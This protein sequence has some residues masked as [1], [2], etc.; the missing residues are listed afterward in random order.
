MYI[1]PCSNG[2]FTE[3]LHSPKLEVSAVSGRSGSSPPEFPDLAQK[4]I[5]REE[6]RRY[7]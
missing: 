1:P 5:V 6:E 4:E 3:E 2:L 7:A